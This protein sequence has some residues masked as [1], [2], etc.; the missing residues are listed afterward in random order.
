MEFGPL[1]LGCITVLSSIAVCVINIKVSLLI[2]S[3]LSFARNSFE[4]VENASDIL[5]GQKASTID[6]AASNAPCLFP[7]TYDQRQQHQSR[8]LKLFHDVLSQVIEDDRH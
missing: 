7:N 4:C 6:F 2:Y 3:D 1:M 8:S 5:L